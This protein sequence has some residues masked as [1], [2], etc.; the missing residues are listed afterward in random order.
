M[1]DS[2]Q[3]R[4][5]GNKSRNKFLSQSLAILLTSFS[6]L[7]TTIASAQIV[8]SVS[9]NPNNGRVSWMA[10]GM[11]WNAVVERASY[12]GVDIIPVISVD[13]KTGNETALP[14]VPNCYYRGTLADTNWNPLPNTHAFINLCNGTSDYFTGFVSNP[15]GVYIIDEN[16]NFPG[17]LLM[18]LD[19]PS[20]PINSPNETSGGNNGKRGKTKEPDTLVPRNST[21]DKF[22]SVEIIVGPSYVEKF[23]DPG[24]VHRIASS[25]AFANF[26]YENSGMKPMTLI[27]INVLT[28]D[29]NQNGGMGAVRHQVLNLRQATVQPN[30]G[31]VS[32]LMLSDVVDATYTWGWGF[33]ANACELQ[34][35]VD[36]DEEINTQD[37]GLSS[38]FV[39]DLPSVIQRGWILA[40]EFAHVVGAGHNSND[41]L[42]DGLFME[43]SSLS[44]YVAGC[45]AKSSIY[46]SCVYNPATRQVID[47]YSCD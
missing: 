17:Q 38:A 25:V 44:D 11:Q 19:D 23:G 9:A 35:A 6:L 43:L 12:F 39:I 27:S 42:T 22:P 41:P 34:I 14:S 7:Y 31:D 47:F 4:Y 28:V 46:E 1:F 26:I 40:H 21:P 8:S 20:T 24:F 36:L 37:I 45:A 5:T 3:Y 30:S 15:N 32:I 33:A 16:P 13:T 18:L 10:D 2:H 29:I